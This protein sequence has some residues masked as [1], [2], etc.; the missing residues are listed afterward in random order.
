MHQAHSLS[1]CLTP[2]VLIVLASC[3]P[4]CLCLPLCAATRLPCSAIESK[5]LSLPARPIHMHYTILCALLHAV[6]YPTCGKLTFLLPQQ[7]RLLHPT[8]HHTPRSSAPGASD[9]PKLLVGD[10]P[11]FRYGEGDW[12]TPVQ[13]TGSGHQF[14]C[15]N[16]GGH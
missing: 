6:M 2:S 4:C 12:K 10:L 14:A 1:L 11:P 16:N 5:R 9:I 7:R 8:L 13:P 3:S 15:A